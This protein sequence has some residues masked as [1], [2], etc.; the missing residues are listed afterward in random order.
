M[1]L[2]LVSFVLLLVATHAANPNNPKRAGHHAPAL[3]P[4]NFP[5]APTSPLI[6]TV[7]PVAPVAPTAT[8]N[9]RPT[10]GPRKVIPDGSHGK[11]G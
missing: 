9:P 1:F 7:A 4:T 8:P 5:V 3:R 11:R 10:N 2:R 6:I